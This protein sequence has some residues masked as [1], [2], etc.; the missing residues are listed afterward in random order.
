MQIYEFSIEN[1]SYVRFRTHSII[2]CLSVDTKG[3]QN[4]TTVY[5][6]IIKK[7]LILYNNGYFILEVK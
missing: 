2:L 3:N 1:L 5:I 7:R 6:F 4:G